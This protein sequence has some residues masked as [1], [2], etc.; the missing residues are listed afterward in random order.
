MAWQDEVEAIGMSGLEENRG[1][2]EQSGGNGETSQGP[3]AN[4]VPLKDGRIA[5]AD[6]I[7]TVTPPEDGGRWPI[8]RPGK[9]VQLSVNGEIIEEAH[10][11]GPDDVVDMKPLDEKPSAE[12]HV[13]V[14]STKMQATASIQRHAG[15]RFQIFD[16]PGQPYARISAELAEIV[17]PP[18]VSVQE[19]LDKLTEAGVVFGIKEAEVQDLAAN[20]SPQPKVVAE[21]MPP[22]EPEDGVIRFL[23]TEIAEVDIDYTASRI[24]LYDRHAISWVQPRDV[25]AEKIEPVPGKPGTDVFG[26][27]IRP[28]NYRNPVLSAGEGVE[29]IK[30][31]QR[32]VA[33]H[34]GRPILDGKTLKVVPTFIV[35]GNAD[36]GTGHVRFS[37]DVVISGDVL[38]RVEVASGGLVEVSGLVSHAK[39]HG[40]QGVIVEKSVIGG[41]IEA[42]GMAAACKRNLS[43]VN[44]LIPKLGGLIQAVQQLQGD[45]RMQQLRLTDGQVVQR[46]LESK[47]STIPKYIEELDRNMSESAALFEDFASLLPTL[48]SKLLGLGP[49]GIGSRWELRALLDSLREL[50]LHL[51]AMQAEVARFGR[52]L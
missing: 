41:Q 45:V 24:D 31:G 36:A 9:N 13:S 33:T 3:E 7:V 39:V 40:Q 5:I 44:S 1:D 11:L 38:D 21:G 26:N 25:L 43:V 16:L 34:E 18:D 51:E 22:T 10:T 6:G 27:A 29:I 15:K 23:F 28:R 17:D 4:D 19:I 48:R 2:R 50:A 46:L 49:V 30:D 47:F 35:S 52:S 42:G 20:P 37:G 12:I 32:A 8:I 14:S